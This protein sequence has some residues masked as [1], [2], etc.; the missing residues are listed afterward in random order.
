M[1]T[2][3]LDILREHKESHAAIQRMEPEVNMHAEAISSLTALTTSLRTDV[4]TKLAE[5]GP[6]KAEVQVQKRQLVSGLNI[7][8]LAMALSNKVSC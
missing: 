4:T 6:L 3:I 5:F 7:C 8:N 1:K 2:S